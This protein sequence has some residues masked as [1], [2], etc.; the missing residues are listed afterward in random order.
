MMHQG[1]A[2]KSLHWHL[3][4]LKPSGWVV[5]FLVLLLCG[6]GGTAHAIQWGNIQAITE[7]RLSGEY[8][9]NVNLGSD[10]DT[11][12]GVG[13]EV[14][15]D[16]VFHVM[17]TIDVLLPHKDH[18]FFLNLGGDYRKG[19]D[20]DLSET[21]VNVSGGVD[22]SFS[23]GLQLRLSDTYNR[24][25][26]DQDLYEVP[27][28][29]DSES[30]TYSVEAAYTFVQRLG[31]EGKYDHRWEEFEEDGGTATRDIDI[32][33]GKLSIPVTRA[34]VAYISCAFEIQDSDERTN[35]NYQDNRY[36]VGAKWTGPYRFS[37][38]AEGGYEDI[39]FELPTQRDY[40]NVVGE[41][42]IEVKLTESSEAALSFGK[43]GYDNTIYEGS[44][45]CHPTEDASARFSV[46]KRTPTTFTGTFLSSVYESTRLS[47][48]LQKRF[49]DRVTA[50]LEGSYQIQEPASEVEHRKDK[51]WIGRISLDYPIQEWMK[52]GT[53]YQ[54]ATRKSVREQDEYEDNRVGMFA[55]LTY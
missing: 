21:N 6:L 34:I 54:Y 26:F 4:R 7:V 50:T 16:F 22:L 5:I 52:V 23:G 47:L 33:D 18:T 2:E 8:D 44:I 49:I 48:Q 11:I 24:S 39:N 36:V 9:D 13:E 51:I 20:T 35:R 41:I 15:D 17:P 46:S 19:T 32:F 40:D 10:V 12:G 1:V 3:P 14:Q 28:I 38:W 27:G 29:S 53:H 42:G 43:D 31:V 37:V 45:V 55:T 25:S 30:N